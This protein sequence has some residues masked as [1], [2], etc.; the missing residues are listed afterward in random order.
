MT[1]QLEEIIK[2]LSFEWPTMDLL[3]Q[4]LDKIADGV[5][6]PSCPQHHFE[7]ACMLCQLVTVATSSSTLTCC[8]FRL[9]KF[10]FSCLPQRFMNPG[11]R[12]IDNTGS[13]L[14]AGYAVL[15]AATSSEAY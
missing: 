4:I 7:Q 2:A 3:H 10:T 12:L 13:A 14:P 5:S 1:A 11:I 6:Q 9:T 8:C 15:V